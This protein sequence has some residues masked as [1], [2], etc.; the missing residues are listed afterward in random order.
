MKLPKQWRA[1]EVK[2]QRLFRALLKCSML[3]DEPHGVVSAH[4][5]AAR[6]GKGGH[7]QASGTRAGPQR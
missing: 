4:W 1:R 7:W 2:S 3:A 5:G 6:T